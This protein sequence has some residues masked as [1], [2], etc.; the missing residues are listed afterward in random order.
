MKGTII[1]FLSLVIMVMGV[2]DPAK[3]SGWL[4]VCTD[5]NKKCNSNWSECKYTSATEYSCLS[6]PDCPTDYSCCLVPEPQAA[7]SANKP[8][9]NDGNKNMCYYKPEPKTD[10]LLCCCLCCCGCG[11]IILII[12]VVMN[13]MNKTKP[14]AVLR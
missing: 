6:Q 7:D 10:A 2:D 5:V 11:L 3:C 8:D 4:V 1:V 14:Q 13:Q 9:C 12:I